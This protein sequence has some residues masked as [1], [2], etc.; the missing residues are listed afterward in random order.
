MA[1]LPRAPR[2]MVSALREA[3]KAADVDPRDVAAVNLAHLL[4]QSVDDGR[5]ADA[6]KLLATMGALGLTPTG[7]KPASAPAGAEST[8]ESAGGESGVSV[9]DQL[10]R[11]RAQ[12]RP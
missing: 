6:P 7:R 8:H 10:R 9:L 3:L 2:K 5:M 4:A 12:Q 11:E 1:D